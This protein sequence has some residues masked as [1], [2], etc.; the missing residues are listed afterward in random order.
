MG[1][2]RRPVPVADHVGRHQD[3]EADYDQA[4]R[5]EDTKSSAGRSPLRAGG[6]Q[7]E[8]FFAFEGSVPARGVAER[9]RI[10]AEPP[11]VPHRRLVSF[12]SVEAQLLGRLHQ[13][14]HIHP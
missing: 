3:Q 1:E 13:L 12:A 14:V 4:G 9:D 7:P 6:D 10:V 2:R 5:H 11:A 8:A